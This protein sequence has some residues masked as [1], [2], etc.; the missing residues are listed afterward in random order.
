MSSG[1]NALHSDLPNAFN[2]LWLSLLV[3]FS[4]VAQD[5]EVRASFIEYLR[6]SVKLSAKPNDT[7]PTSPTKVVVAVVMVLD[8][9]SNIGYA[10]AGFMYA[11]MRPRMGVKSLLFLFPPTLS[12]RK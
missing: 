11:F 3:R 1:F 6:R 9:V 12:T 5:V 7:P 8:A 2:V 10:L 4:H